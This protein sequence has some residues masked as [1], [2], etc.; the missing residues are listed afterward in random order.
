MED[1]YQSIALYDSECGLYNTFAEFI[2]KKDKEHQFKFISLQSVE[3]QSILKK[4]ELSTV[5]FSSLV[6]IK[7]AQFYLKS[8]A[9]LL[10]LKDLG[11]IWKL[12]YCFMLI[13]Q[14]IRDFIYDS[15]AKNRHHLFR[16]Q[17]SCKWSL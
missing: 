9:S 3:G 10:L 17:K 1:F 14:P 4:N 6:Y 8:S 16:K 5:C 12:F 15:I 13:P 11:G 2:L 7:Q